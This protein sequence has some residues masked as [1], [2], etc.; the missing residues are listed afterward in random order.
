MRIFLLR[1]AL[2]SL[3]VLALLGCQSSESSLNTPTWSMSK[4]N[5]FSKGSGETT[6]PTKPSG[7]AAPNVTSPPGA[8]YADATPGAPG[9]SGYT[10]VAPKYEPSTNAYA[11]TGDPYA[12]ASTD[13]LL[14]SAAS[15]N[16]AATPQSGYYDT[17]SGYGLAGQPG[18]T[19]SY[20][21]PVGASTPSSDYRTA[22]AGGRYGTA[23][24][25]APRYGVVADRY[26]L[27]RGPSQPSTDLSAGRA[28]AATY[29]AIPDYSAQTPAPQG[30]GSRY[31]SAAGPDYSPSPDS[32]YGGDWS[33]SGLPVADSRYDGGSAYGADAR[34]LVGD[35]YTVENTQAAGFNSYRDRRFSNS[36]ADASWTPGETGYVPG[37]SDYEPG[38]TGY[39]PPG[40]SPYRSPADS[41]STKPFL[42]GSTRTYTPRTTNGSALPAGSL[43]DPQTEPRADSQV[44]PAGHLPSSWPTRTL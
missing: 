20:Q 35:R 25:T 19:P 23:A 42:P 33:G 16:P 14:G 44:I 12:S 18:G 41:Y 28:P 21:P 5:P 30:A 39:Q 8:G 6:Y 31:E 22:G 10:N 13:S 9:Q 11:G 24:G 17:G 7:L 2:V 1:Y 3:T 34:S 4:L 29:P 27:N 36:S 43:S 37:Q 26:G 40:I 15:T 32:R 38:N